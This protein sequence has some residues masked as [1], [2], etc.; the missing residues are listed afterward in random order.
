MR[1]LGRRLRILEWHRGTKQSPISILVHRRSV[2]PSQSYQQL[3]DYLHLWHMVWS[4]RC[5]EWQSLGPDWVRRGYIHER[6]HVLPVV[7]I[8]S[9]E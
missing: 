7:P 8:R 9:C 4:D 6:V 2:D 1:Q 3:P 5:V